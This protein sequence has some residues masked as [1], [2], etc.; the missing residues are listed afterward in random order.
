MG[1][2]SISEPGIRHSLGSILDNIG[3]TP[4]L[5]LK[6]VGGEREGVAI[7]AKAE[8]FNPGGSVKDRAALRIIQDGE[9]SGQLT[10]EKTILDS[11]S[12]N[13]GIAYAMIGA[14]LGY[15]VELVMPGNV[16]EERKRIIAAYGTRMVFTDPLEGYDEAIREVRRIYQ[17]TPEK[18][19]Y[20]NQ[21]DNPS[22]WLA[23]YDTTG[24][25]IIAQTEGRVTHFV[26]GVGTSG[27]LMGVGRRLKEYNP[28][29]KLIAVEPED[30]LQIIEGLK[31]MEDSLLPGIYDEALLDE[32]I[33]VGAED[34]YEMAQRLAREEG[35]FVGP[36]SGA[37]LKGVLKVAKE[38]E[39]GLI[40]TVFPDNGDRYFS[41]GLWENADTRPFAP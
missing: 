26:A 11:T 41:T 15:S 25:E 34:A 22:N 21:Y 12:G 23:H 35:L 10:K 31:H 16:S 4:L 37:A 19:F 27:T 28:S 5:R 40:V 2:V 3:N 7:Y 39:E 24:P 8:W 38:I 32:K 30:E 17:R 6:K 20:A 13:M 18:Y 36:S 9:R 1:D 29:I 14:I 33:R